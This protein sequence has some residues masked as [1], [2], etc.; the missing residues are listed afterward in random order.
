MLGCLR[1]RFT[2]PLPEQERVAVF[3]RAEYRAKAA[4]HSQLAETCQSEEVREVHLR[5]AEWFRL[6]ADEGWL[7][8]GSPIRLHPAAIERDVKNPR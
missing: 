6:L 7:E 5:M 1:N 8:V 3:K 4:E 2:G